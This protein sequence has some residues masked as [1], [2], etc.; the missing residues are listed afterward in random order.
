MPA[1]PGVGLVVE[2]GNPP[3]LFPPP[4]VRVGFPTE[5]GRHGTGLARDGR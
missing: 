2:A 5:R 3:A 1:P 4:V